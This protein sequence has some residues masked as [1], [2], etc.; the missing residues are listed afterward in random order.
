[1]KKSQSILLLSGFVPLVAAPIIIVA[2]CS[3]S[4]TTPTDTTTEAKYTIV[5]N[6][7]KSFVV[8]PPTTPEQGIQ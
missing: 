3:N 6:T 7:N 8:K 1:M 5:F 2:S 4:E